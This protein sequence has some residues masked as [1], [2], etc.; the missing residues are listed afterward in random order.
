M[1]LKRLA[2]ARSCKSLQD[3]IPRAVGRQEGFR[4]ERS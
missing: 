3:F 1:M 2:R 4:A